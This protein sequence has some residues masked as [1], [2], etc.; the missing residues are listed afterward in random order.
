M[1]EIKFRAWDDKDKI[2]YSE[3]ALDLVMHFD[4]E[5]NSIDFETGEI[6]G[7]HYTKELSIMQYTGLNDK[8]GLEIYEGDIIKFGNQI[9]FI[10]EMQHGC[11]TFVRKEEYFKCDPLPMFHMSFKYVE[12]IGNIYENPELVTELN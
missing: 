10:G 2:M 7:T 1:R 11:Y 8:N 4:G 9:G 5:L 12:V 6:A 3:K